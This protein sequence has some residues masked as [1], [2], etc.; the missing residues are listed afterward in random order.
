M[1]DD[2]AGDI[3][4]N[5][6]E[7]PA[8]WSHYFSGMS[9]RGVASFIADAIERGALD[10]LAECSTG[11]CMECGELSLTFRWNRPETDAEVQAKLDARA[12]KRKSKEDAERA[13]LARL[14]AK[15]EEGT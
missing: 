14:K 8:R 9:A 1:A 2:T 5:R 11:D 4:A 10:P 7:R 12:R 15:Y 13:E 3:D 6:G